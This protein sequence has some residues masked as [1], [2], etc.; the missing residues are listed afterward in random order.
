MAKRKGMMFTGV[1]VLEGALKEIATMA[2]VKKVVKT[3]TVELTRNATRK[4]P[5]DSGYL[6]RSNQMTLSTNRLSG[7]VFNT[8]NYAG[9]VNSGTRFMAAQPFMTNSYRVQRDVFLH[10]MKRLVK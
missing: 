8:A 1:N 5:V 6:K 10:D 2:D 3:N 7:K 9:Y 4:A